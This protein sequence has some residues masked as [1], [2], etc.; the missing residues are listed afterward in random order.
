MKQRTDSRPT[1]F[2]ASHAPSIVSFSHEEP[3]WS[4]SDLLC[5]EQDRRKQE[6]SERVYFCRI[7]YL[8]IA[9]RVRSI[10]Q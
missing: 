10:G 6:N 7:L 3:R 8:R 4:S 5:V 2:A 1:L 9:A